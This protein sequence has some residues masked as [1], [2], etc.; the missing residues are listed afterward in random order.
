[1]AS[2]RR[3]SPRTQGRIVDVAG[4]L[5]AWRPTTEGRGAINLAVQDESAPWNTGTWRVEFAGSEVSV[6]RTEGGAAGLA[7]H[8]GAFASLFRRTDPR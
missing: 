5:Q 8:S 3:F 6:Q 4:A 1:M 2:R 7:R